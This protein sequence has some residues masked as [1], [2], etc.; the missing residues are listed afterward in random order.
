MRVI[1]LDF[2]EGPLDLVVKRVSKEREDL[3]LS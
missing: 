3:G 2:R 1:F